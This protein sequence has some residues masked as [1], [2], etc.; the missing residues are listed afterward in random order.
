[1]GKEPGIRAVYRARCGK[2]TTN[3]VET[4]GYEWDETADKMIFITKEWADGIIS[5]NT[6]EALTIANA[7]CPV[8]VIWD[9][10]VGLLVMLHC[11]L[12]TLVP[13]DGSDGILATFFRRYRPVHTM[14]AS[15]GFGAGPCCFGFSKFVPPCTANSLVTE[16][17][18][19]IATGIDPTNE[20]YG[21]PSIDL[22]ALMESQL[23]ELG[24]KP[25]QIISNEM[26][27]LRCTA[28][29]RDFDGSRMYHSNAWDGKDAGRNLS[30]AIR[31]R[32]ISEPKC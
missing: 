4:V 7:D 18:M 25:G 2:M 32:D 31:R 23:L 24:M 22:C 9:L 3:I 20:R 1:M 12:Q 30:V 28:C 19:G 13:P 11:A 27:T 21:K 17:P 26:S 29:K 6:G 16:W 5:W 8:I 15:F 10:D 14:R